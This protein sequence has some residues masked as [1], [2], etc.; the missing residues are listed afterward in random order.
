MLRHRFLGHRGQAV[1]EREQQIGQ[2]HPV[3]ELARA[4]LAHLGERHLLHPRMA[5]VTD[6]QLV[7]QELVQAVR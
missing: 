3:G 7:G 1:A 6:G 2:G 4:R 5:E